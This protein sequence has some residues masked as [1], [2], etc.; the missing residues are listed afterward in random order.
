MSY[1]DAADRLVTEARN[2]GFEVVRIDPARQIHSAE[3]ITLVNPTGSTI[4]FMVE[5]VMTGRHHFVPID[6]LPS[7]SPGPG[8]GEGTELPAAPI[9]FFWPFCPTHHDEPFGG[10]LVDGAWHGGEHS[11]IDEARSEA[12]NHNAT[13]GHAALVKRYIEA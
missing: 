1:D 12:E 9:V 5:D 4:G 11:T 2:L 6:G 10:T 7:P 13:T 8:T 3:D